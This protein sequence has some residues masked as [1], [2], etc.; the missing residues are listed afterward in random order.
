ML[1]IVFVEPTIK[2]MIQE[3]NKTTT[4]RSAVAISES[5]FRMPH[6]A[7][8]EVRP[9]NTAEKTAITSHS[10]DCHQPFHL[11]A[12]DVPTKAKF[13]R[14]HCMHLITQWQA[15]I[16]TPASARPM[17]ESGYSIPYLFTFCKRDGK[18]CIWKQTTGSFG[19]TV[20][21]GESEERKNTAV[22][23]QKTAYGSGCSR[24]KLRSRGDSN[25]RP[26]A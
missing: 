4:V 9:A 5:V 22:N 26:I 10:I 15:R 20:F 25:T 12:S 18:S 3:N 2:T 11:H 6:F 23:H 19:K 24:R 13:R 1:P 16:V 7:S 14:V 21:A 17:P 8:M